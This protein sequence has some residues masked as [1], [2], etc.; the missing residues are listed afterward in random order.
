MFLWAHSCSHP[1]R[2]L[3]QFSHFRRTRTR[4]HDQQTKDRPCYCY[5]CSNSL[6]LIFCTAMWPKT[7]SFQGY[8]Y[9]PYYKLTTETMMSAETVSHETIK[10]QRYFQDSNQT[11]IINHF[12]LF[13]SKYTAIQKYNNTL[14]NKF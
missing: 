6:H 1:K 12:T 7:E 13:D 3:D 10:W 4:S 5:M 11:K 2:H 14:V 8:T 9:R